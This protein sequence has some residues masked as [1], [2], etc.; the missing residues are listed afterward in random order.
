MST[1]TTSPYP[2]HLPLCT[3]HHVRNF[4]MFSMSS[5]TWAPSHAHVSVREN[6]QIFPIFAYFQNFQICPILQLILWSPLDLV[7]KLDT[8]EL[9]PMHMNL[10]HYSSNSLLAHQIHPEF[11]SENW[12]FFPISPPFCHWH[13]DHSINSIF[14]HL[15][16][17]IISIR[18]WIFLYSISRLHSSK[19]L[20]K[21]L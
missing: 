8:R 1:D 12:G 19:L 13:H 10:T 14:I 17:Q 6:S 20:T 11:L 4:H 15:Q 16:V 18:D 3:S 9:G 21:F 2:L 7:I 5:D